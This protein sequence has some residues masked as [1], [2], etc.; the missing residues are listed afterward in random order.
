M[1]KSVSLSLSLSLS[2]VFM[3]LVDVLEQSPSLINA[4]ILHG[5]L[6]YCILKKWKLSFTCH[7]MTIHP[8]SS[9]TWRDLLWFYITER[10]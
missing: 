9:L 7:P 6:E 8:Q 4:R 10:G 3:L 5:D 2:L 1:D